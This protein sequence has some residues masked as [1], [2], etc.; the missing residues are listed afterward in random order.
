MTTRI[1]V[2]AI[3]LAIAT[4]LLIARLVRRRGLRSKYAL[5]WISSAALLLPLSVFPGLLDWYADLIGIHYPPTA[6]AL[7]AMAVLFVVAFHFSWELSRTEDRCP[8][9]R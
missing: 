8:A 3:L 6:L 4:V 5:L 9:S 7:T 1:H 2:L